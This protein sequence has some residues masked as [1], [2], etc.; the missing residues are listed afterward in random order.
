MITKSLQPNSPKLMLPSLGN[1][2]EQEL[3]PVPSYDFLSFFISSQHS[4]VAMDSLL[5]LSSLRLM[6][7][8]NLLLRG[9]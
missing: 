4:K 5:S 3:Y 2:R 8:R 6:L 7:L 1:L 9:F